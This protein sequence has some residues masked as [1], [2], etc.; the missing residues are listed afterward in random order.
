MT[1]ILEQLLACMIIL[2]ICGVSFTIYCVIGH[3]IQKAVNRKNPKLR[4]KE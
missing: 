4:N 1:W 2:A 3:L